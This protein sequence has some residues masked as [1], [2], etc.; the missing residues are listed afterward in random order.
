MSCKLL[1][2]HRGSTWRSVDELARAPKLAQ[3]ERVSV[4]KKTNKQTN[5]QTRIKSGAFLPKFVERRRPIEEKPPSNFFLTKTNILTCLSSSS[6]IPS[7][8]LLPCHVRIPIAH[9]LYLL[10]FTFLS[11][12]KLDQSAIA[13][14][15]RQP[16]G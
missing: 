8:P 13:A 6:S 2:C 3:Q 10:C 9:Q 7:Y 1:Q 4:H 11:L 16:S 12:A 15:G 14:Q 5:K